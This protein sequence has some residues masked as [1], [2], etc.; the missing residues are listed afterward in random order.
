MSEYKINDLINQFL[1]KSQ[2]SQLYYERMAIQLWK[3]EL[4]DFISRYTKNVT[5]RSGVMR[6]SLLHASL[7]FEMMGRK[8]E[9]INILNEK[10]G[11]PIVKDILFN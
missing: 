7:K 6:V 8:S 11:F 5:L 4:G 3:T 9:I 2:K 10:V 1:D